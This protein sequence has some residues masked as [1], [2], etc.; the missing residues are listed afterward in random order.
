MWPHVAAAAAAAVTTTELQRPGLAGASDGGPRGMVYSGLA[1]ASRSVVAEESVRTVTCA[2]AFY[3]RLLLLLLTVVCFCRRRQRTRGNTRR[4][5]STE[6]SGLSDFDVSC[7]IVR[8]RSNARKTR[9]PEKQKK[10]S[11]LFTGGVADGDPSLVHRF[12]GDYVARY[13]VTGR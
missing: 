7:Q 1:R 3:S 12:H 5:I 13:R 2:C 4:V 8:E 6:R 10:G 9:K 11:R